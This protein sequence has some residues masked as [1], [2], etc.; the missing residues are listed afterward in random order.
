MWNVKDKHHFYNLIWIF[1]LFSENKFNNVFKNS[2]K[3]LKCDNELR[4]DFVLNQSTF[5]LY[6]D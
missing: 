6:L 3:K 1:S 4:I 5:I 2:F